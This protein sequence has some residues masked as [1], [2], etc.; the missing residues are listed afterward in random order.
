MK[1]NILFI[2][3]ILVLIIPQT[4][5]AAWWNP[6]SWNIWK[7]INDFFTKP[8][9]QVACTMEAKLCSDGSYVSRQGP[10]CEF[11]ECPPDKTKNI[12]PPADSK[13]QACL[14]SL[15]KVA[16]IN[17]YC[18]STQDFF[19]NCAIGACTCAPDSRYLRKIKSCECPKG[20]CF[21][22]TSCVNQEL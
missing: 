13:E 11:A 16:Q 20:E 19:N 18:S 15:G 8:V 12:L 9:E 17:C 4:V 10:K 5:L 14:E 21:D 6:F 3:L 2:I 22:G 1:K 7:S